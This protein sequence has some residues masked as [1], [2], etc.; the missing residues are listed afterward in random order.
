MQHVFTLLKKEFTKEGGKIVFANFT[1]I[2]IDTERRDLFETKQ[3]CE[4]LCNRVKK[5]FVLLSLYDL[6]ICV[7]MEGWVVVYAF[8]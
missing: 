4:D 8:I 6:I 3:C 5:G 7:H 1:N 2:L